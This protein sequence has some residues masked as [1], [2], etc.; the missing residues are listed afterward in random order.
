[1]SIIN[2]EIEALR[3][4]L[5]NAPNKHNIS[6]AVGDMCDRAANALRELQ[7]LRDKHAALTLDRDAWQKTA[8]G[9]QD[10]LRAMRDQREADARHVGRYRWLCD[11]MKIGSVTT[12]LPLYRCRY[13]IIREAIED[14]STIGAAID[15]AMSAQGE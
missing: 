1:M 10:E 5:Y 15:A 14:H 2:D 7:A 4:E 13:V 8:E 9:L 11:Q 3:A 6:G 12:Q